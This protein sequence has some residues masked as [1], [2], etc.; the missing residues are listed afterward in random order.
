[1][2]SSLILACKESGK[3]QRNY[4]E[5]AKTKKESGVKRTIQYIDCT[6]RGGGLS[7]CAIN[8][9]FTRDAV[10]LKKSKNYNIDSMVEE[11]D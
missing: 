5:S 6:E 7:A 9:D 11:A 8:C 2:K 1:M 4:Q 10:K 3:Q